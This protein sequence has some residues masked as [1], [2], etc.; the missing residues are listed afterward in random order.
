MIMIKR[1]NLVSS[2]VEM[3]KFNE[4]SVSKQKESSRDAVCRLNR[5]LSL[6]H[7]N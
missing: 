1:Q 7:F 3:E 6:I 4:E 2:G 5:G